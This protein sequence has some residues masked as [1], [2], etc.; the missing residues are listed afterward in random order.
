MISGGPFIIFSIS[1]RLRKN[2]ARLRRVGKKLNLDNDLEKK[3][4]RP[5][6]LN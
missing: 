3:T 2:M 1:S 4:K 5:G 6:N